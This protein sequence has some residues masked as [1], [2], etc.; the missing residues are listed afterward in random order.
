M[1]Y[2]LSMNK[3]II[4]IC[5]VAY[6]LKNMLKQLHIYY[7]NVINSSTF[8]YCRIKIIHSKL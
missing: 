1:Y 6:N 4:F 8:N 2:L 3:T 7:D 5:D